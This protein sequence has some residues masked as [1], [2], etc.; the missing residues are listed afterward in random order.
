M[1]TKKDF[2]ELAKQLALTRQEIE[3]GRT[4]GPEVVDALAGWLRCVNAVGRALR[5]TSARFDFERFRAACQE[6][7]K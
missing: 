6:G 3:A 4:G 2:E 1:A 5:T 7:E